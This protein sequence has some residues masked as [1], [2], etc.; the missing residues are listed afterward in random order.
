MRRSCVENE[1]TRLE[2]KRAAYLR[3]H[4]EKRELAPELAAK[5]PVKLRATLNLAFVKAFELIFDKGTKLIDK[6]YDKEQTRIQYEINR[7]AVGLKQDKRSLRAFSKETSA[8]GAL[9]LVISGAEGIGLG[10]LGCGIPDIPIL[11]ATLLRSLYELAASY[12]HDYTQ[13]EERLYLLMLIEGAMSYGDRLDDCQSRLD[14]FAQSD[15]LCGECGNGATVSGGT[16]SNRRQVSED[17]IRA[18]L[19]AA[20]SA[21]ADETLF[22]KFVQGIPLVGVVGG[23]SNPVILQRI[24]QYALLNYQYRML[25]NLDRR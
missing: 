21:L 7:Y 6:T 3:N 4:R 1:L 19:H 13:P 12:G 8:S 22:L 11:S 2:K 25:C 10:L 17:D 5:V 16:A 24:R 14:D 9:N 23:L 15:T 18:Q 20:A